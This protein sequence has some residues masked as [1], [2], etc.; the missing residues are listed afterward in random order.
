MQLLHGEFP[1]TKAYDLGYYL[2]IPQSKLQE[3]NLINMSDMEAM[4][5]SII[6]FWLDMDTEKSWARLAT[7]MEDCGLGNLASKVKMQFE[8]AD[9][10]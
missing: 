5:V 10:G 4:V 1:S 7:A 8:I 3:F 2:D 6:N 9:E